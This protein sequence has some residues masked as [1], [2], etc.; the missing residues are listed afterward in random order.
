MVRRQKDKASSPAKMA[1]TFFGLDADTQ[2]PLCFT[3]ASSARTVTQATPELLTLA[4]SI[5][6][7][8]GGKP[9]ALADNELIKVESFFN[10][11]LPSLPLIC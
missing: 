9:L 8:N 3:T 4:A 2:Q 11:F 1:Q 6:K 5:I 7:L 10:G